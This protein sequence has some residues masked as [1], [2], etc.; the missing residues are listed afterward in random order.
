MVTIVAY[1]RQHVSLGIFPDTSE[2]EN[3]LERNFTP[4]SEPKSTHLWSIGG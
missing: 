4:R 2:S 1:L 3:Q